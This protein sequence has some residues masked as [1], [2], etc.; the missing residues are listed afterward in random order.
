MAKKV[1]DKDTFYNLAAKR[2]AI[3]R[4]F[5]IHLTIYIIIMISLIKFNLNLNTCYCCSIFPFLGWGFGVCM[6][7]FIVFN[8]L[9]L[10]C[11]K[12]IYK[13]IEKIKDEIENDL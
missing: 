10:F 7:G 5:F 11:D 4:A 6:H 1:I 9:C 2:L 12:T 13:E 3:K 8:D